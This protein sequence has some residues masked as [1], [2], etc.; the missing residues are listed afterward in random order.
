MLRIN[1]AHQLRSQD[2]LNEDVLENFLHCYVF[3]QLNNNVVTPS[4]FLTVPLSSVDRTETVWFRQQRV[5]NHC[6]S[7]C[8]NH[9]SRIRHD[10]RPENKCP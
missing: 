10:L 8:M 2:K 4:E 3:P 6:L 5:M 9:R 7:I 1:C